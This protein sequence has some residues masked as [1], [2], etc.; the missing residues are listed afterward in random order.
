MRA[1]LTFTLNVDSD[2]ELAG[3][4]KSA[5]DLLEGQAQVSSHSRQLEG[6]TFTVIGTIKGQP[7]ESWRVVV[8]AEDADEA[9]EQASGGDERRNVVA[10]F[11]GQ[12]EAE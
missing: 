12:V 5:A 2:E 10:V 7:S 4:E 3:L 9:R 6:E 8:R 11:K 1:T